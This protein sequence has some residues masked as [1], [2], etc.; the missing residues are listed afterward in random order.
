M[1]FTHQLEQSCP[2]FL[3]ILLVLRPQIK[4]VASGPIQWIEASFKEKI[5]NDCRT[6]CSTNNTFS[7]FRCGSD[8][9]CFFIYSWREFIV[10][11]RPTLLHRLGRFYQQ[12][13]W[14]SFFTFGLR[15]FC[16]S[17]ADRPE[18]V[19]KIACQRVRPFC[20]SEADLPQQS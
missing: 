14:A 8:C 19:S 6:Y 2:R 3:T 10:R 4:F 9:R 20:V 12:S 5:S 7:Y 16:V 13:W 18:F 11:P 15:A 17:R 1:S